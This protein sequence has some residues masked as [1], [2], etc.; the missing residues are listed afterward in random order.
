MK[1]FHLWTS[2]LLLFYILFINFD[3]SSVNGLEKKDKGNEVTK[4]KCKEHVDEALRQYWDH[5]KGGPNGKDDDKDDDEDESD[6]VKTDEEDDEDSKQ[7]SQCDDDKNDDNDDDEN[8]DEDKS[9]E[10][11]KHQRNSKTD[12]KD[13]EDNSEDEDQQKSEENKDEDK[14]DDDS[15]ESDSKELPKS[16]VEISKQK[17]STKN[18]EREKVDEDNEDS[19][20]DK[21]ESKG[22]ESDDKSDDKTDEIDNEDDEEAQKH[23]HRSRT[24]ID[25]ILRVYEIGSQEDTT[26]QNLILSIF[27]ELK[28]LYE[29]T[30]KPLEI[31]YKYRH[32]TTR[33]FTDA[34]LFAKPT[35]LFLGGK[36]TGKTSLVNYLL[37]IDSTPWQLK[38][39]LT[40]TYPHFTILSYGENYTRLSP[41]ELSAD[42]AFSSLQQFGQPFLEHYIEAHRL[43]INILQKVCSLKV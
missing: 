24:H 30:V 32:I 27:R 43:P 13:D 1:Y 29:S 40:S 4:V 36:S 8:D 3:Y 11:D 22:K 20:E 42:F 7:D 19:D 12:S 41:T 35:V 34:E 28:R 21:N 17:I 2:A 15:N 10:K 31:I 25:D 14:D 9:D 16:K 39:G 6:E 33:L 5:E 37:G 18:T 38:T 23:E 26:E